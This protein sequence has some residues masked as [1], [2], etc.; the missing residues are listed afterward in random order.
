[1]SDVEAGAALT[2]ADGALDAFQHQ[3]LTVALHGAA[4]RV[5]LDATWQNAAQCHECDLTAP[6]LQKSGPQRLAGI[7]PCSADGQLK[8]RPNVKRGHADLALDIAFAV[9]RHRQAAAQP[10]TRQRAVDVFKFELAAFKRNVRRQADVLGELVGWLETE[11]R[12][13][14]ESPRLHRDADLR[15]RCKRF[16]GSRCLGGEA[17]AR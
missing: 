2:A 16:G 17:R 5:Q 1:M 11:Q 13:E 3:R 6:A 15:L 8:G 9:E 7:T 14:V 12:R 10:R 4:D